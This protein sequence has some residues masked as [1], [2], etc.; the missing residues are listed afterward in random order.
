MIHM[1]EQGT[2]C[3]GHLGAEL[4]MSSGYKY[5]QV[6]SQMHLARIEKRLLLNIFYFTKRQ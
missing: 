3:K 2:R 6:L 4:H 5:F 1:W